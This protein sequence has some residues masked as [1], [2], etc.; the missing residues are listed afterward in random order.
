MVRKGGFWGNS[1]VGHPF[2]YLAAGKE[3]IKNFLSGPSDEGR[4]Y[5]LVKDF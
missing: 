1:P 5:V 4:G 2:I 3:D